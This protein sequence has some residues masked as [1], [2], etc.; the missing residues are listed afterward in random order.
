MSNVSRN[1]DEG[2]G[3]LAHVPAVQ[4]RAILIDALDEL[5]E[6]PLFKNEERLVVAIVEELE[7]LARALPE[8]GALD[9]GQFGALVERV[10]LLLP[11]LPSRSSALV[12]QIRQLVLTIEALAPK[13]HHASRGQGFG[14]DTLDAA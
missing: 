13:R 6:L 10:Q 9:N 5:G 14:S 3:A 4:I 8:H 7:R 11:K 12:P 2:V 1:D